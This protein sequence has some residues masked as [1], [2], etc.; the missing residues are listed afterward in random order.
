MTS[1]SLPGV[2]NLA[3]AS[4]SLLS[5]LQ[6]ERIDPEQDLSLKISILSLSEEEFFSPH[7]CARTYFKSRDCD[8]EW[9]GLGAADYISQ[10]SANEASALN[11]VVRKVNRLDND[12][13]YFGGMRFD[14]EQAISEEWKDFKFEIFIL[15]LILVRHCRSG[16]SLSL[17][18]RVDGMPFRIWRDH[19][20]TLLR[21]LQVTRIAPSFDKLIFV[22]Q[23]QPEQAHYF[24]TIK[25]ALVHFSESS[26]QKKVV[27]GRRNARF[28]STPFDPAHLFFRLARRSRHAFLFMFD[29]GLGGTFFGASPELLYRRIGQNFET[30]SLAGTRPR[31]HDHEKDVSLRQELLES[32]KDK[33][34]HFLVSEHIE[35]RLR[36]FGATDLFTSKLEIMSLPYV[37]HLHRRYHGRI[38]HGL[39]DDTIISALHPTPAVC[40]IDSDWAKQFIRDHEGFDRGFYAAPI[41]YVAKNSAE[42]AVGIRSAL[43][44]ASRL[45]I[46]AACGIVRGSVPEQEWEELNNKQKNILAIFE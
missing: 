41:G 14:K 43:Y 29:T 1:Y 45:F 4:C 23:E 16:F 37:Q 39:S 9:W 27:I 17:N 26:E 8:L 13:I 36:E 42:F 2:L 10:D 7:G 34:E 30:E 11:Q 15:P 28:F 44:Q 6:K 22:D 19:A 24:R 20:E 33:S 40:G 3:E 18:Y 12:Q 31:S 25:R 5:W 38:Q 46:Y 21:S 32:I 35:E